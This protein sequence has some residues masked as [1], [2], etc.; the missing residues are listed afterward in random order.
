MTG[1]L[2][3]DAGGAAGAAAVGSGA[4][5]DGAAEV[6]G[7]EGA[8]AGGGAIVAATAGGEAA[9]GATMLASLD[10]SGADS[11]P[12]QRIQIRR[13]TAAMPT[14]MTTRAGFLDGGR[15]TGRKFWKS[16]MSPPSLRTGRIPGSSASETPSG[17]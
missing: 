8:A 13:R 10:A 17:A 15:I 4:A 1:G 12:G 3:V 5:G 7:V 2:E 14:A 6:A 9:F 16:G 11:V